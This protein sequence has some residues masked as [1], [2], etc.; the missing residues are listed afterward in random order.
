MSLNT[1]EACATIPAVQAS[2]YQAKGKYETHG[3]IKTYVT[4]NRDADKAIYFIYDI[5][6]Y[7][8]QTLQGAD[9]LAHSGKY[10]VVIPDFFKGEPI[11]MEWYANPTEENNAKKQN[12]MKN[13][14]FDKEKDIRDHLDEVKKAFPKVH[15][16]GAI[17]Y[18]W[19]GKLVAL[20]SKQNTPWAVAVQSS[21][22]KM[23]AED[24]KALTIPFGT[25]ASQGEDKDVVEAFDKAQTTPKMVHRFHDRVHGFMSARSNL[26]EPEEVKAYEKG[27]QLTLDFFDK[28]L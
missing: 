7:T 15:K 14:S 18:C 28:H 26:K 3:G 25:L 19:G 24:A 8:D 21:P 9:I 5:F 20:T 2:G 22:A 11:K 13:L 10:L 4:G 12:F 23:D 17:G 27:Y 1:S 6:G 16:W